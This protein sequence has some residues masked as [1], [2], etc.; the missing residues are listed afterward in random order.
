MDVLAIE[1][2]GGEL[3]YL[4][5]LVVSAALERSFRR[6][7][8]KDEVG[9]FL[10]CVSA[11]E[12]PFVPGTVVL[13]AL[14]RVASFIRS[15]AESRIASG[16]PADLHTYLVLFD[17]RG[18]RCQKARV[19]TAFIVPGRAWNDRLDG[20]I[21]ATDPWRDLSDGQTR[22]WTLGALGDVEARAD[23]SVVRPGHVARDPRQGSGFA[24]R[25]EPIELR[26]VPLHEY[27]PFLDAIAWVE[28]RA[29]EQLRFSRR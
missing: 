9:A 6:E 26:F 17:R 16:E 11:Y 27:P 24:S 14:R 21:A 15:D 5:P 10:R 7:L 4:H 19:K 25:E 12:S 20:P 3:A 22:R 28:A 29:G 18:A 13:A 2:S 1:S 23:G 8:P